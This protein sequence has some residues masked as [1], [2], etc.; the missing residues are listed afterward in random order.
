MSRPGAS[1]A[2][3]SSDALRGIPRR[4]KVIARS[5]RRI[6]LKALPDRRRMSHIAAAPGPSQPRRQDSSIQALRGIAVILMVAGHVIGVGNQ[7][8]R[9]G[10]HSAWHYSYLA[11]ADVRMPLFT[12][13]S[14]Y[15]YAMVP[16][17]GWQQYPRLLEGK[18]RRLLYPL[19]TVGT[20]QYVLAC[21]I[22]GANYNPHKLPI[23][24]IYVFGFEH[25]WFLQSIFVIF[26]I[27][28]ILD[29]I[30][31]L[32]SRRGWAVAT[33]VAAVAYVVVQIP[34]RVDVFT[35]SGAVRLLPFFLIGYGLRRHSLLDLRGTPALLAMTAF[36]GFYTVR[37]LAID[38]RFH[39]DGYEDRAIT[40]TVGATALI[41]I[42]SARGYLDAK[43]LAW[44]GGFSFGIYLL[45]DLATAGTRIGLERFGIHVRW[46]LF[47]TG[48]LMGISAPIVFQLLFRNVT[49]IRTF[50]LGERPHTGRH[51]RKRRYGLRRKPAAVE[52]HSGNGSRSEPP[53][54]G[55]A[56][57]RASSAN[58]IASRTA[59]P[60][61][62][63]LK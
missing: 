38:G 53:T 52:I 54:T 63:L 14:G 8:L 56:A 44:I 9:V 42:Y 26:L 2:P 49:V 40:L 34:A 17:A 22:P 16:V 60:P 47:L 23:W 20:L 50:V 27:I 18:S 33:S 55:L 15:V 31:V 12:L 43:P 45:H 10:D 7:G 46:E 35:V 25:L 11:L 51:T 5:A 32:D 1:D 41:L 61:E 39:P 19:I 58:R 36:A 28:G 59:A 30:G 3:G 29:S 24:R 6:L 57:A 13:L 21:N 4:H 48:L 37:L 62:S